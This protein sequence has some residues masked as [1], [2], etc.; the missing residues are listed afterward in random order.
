MPRRLV[1]AHERLAQLRCL[2]VV[3]IGCVNIPVLRQY[4]GG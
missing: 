3:I 4:S 2:S 1:V